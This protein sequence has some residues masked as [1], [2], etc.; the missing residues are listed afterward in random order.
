MVRLQS[1]RVHVQENLLCSSVELVT[2]L[3]AAPKRGRGEAA[4]PRR[5]S[6]RERWCRGGRGR[7]E[8]KEE[9]GKVWVFIYVCDF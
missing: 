3:V 9:R 2:F 7:G 8:A 1:R 4:L 5:E 6:R